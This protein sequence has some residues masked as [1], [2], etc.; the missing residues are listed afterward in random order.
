MERRNTPLNKEQKKAEVAELKEKFQKTKGLVFTEY[1]GM[2]VDELNDLRK[3]LRPA[4]VEYRIV[5]NTLAK[6]ASKD[7]PVEAG[8]SGFKGPIAV[9]LGYDDAAALAKLVLAHAKKQ[10]KLKVMGG[11]VEGKLCSAEQLKQVATLPSREVMLSI[12][13]GTFAAP[14]TQMARLLA[15]TIAQFGYAMTALKDKKAA[16]E[17]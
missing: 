5:K 15:A 11:V 8:V 12:M 16:A 3:M 14:A 7:T 9:A 6:I 13:A 10:P 1:K 4:N 2:T 17:G